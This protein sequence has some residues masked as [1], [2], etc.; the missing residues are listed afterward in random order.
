[1][2][3]LKF[4]IEPVT[5]ILDKIKDIRVVGFNMATLSADPAT[6]KMNIDRNPA[7]RTT[8][9]GTVIKHQIGTI[10]QDWIANFPELLVEPKS[11]EEYYGLAYDR[12][13]VV[14]LGAVKELSKIVSQK[15]A[16]IARLT[17]E[18]AA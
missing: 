14:A 15:D 6:G 4:D 18:L 17:A 11:D 13:G 8:K 10:A 5:G 2:E 16:E 3:R 9:D 7:P 12:I 1:D